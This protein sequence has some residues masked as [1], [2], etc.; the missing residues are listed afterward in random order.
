MRISCREGEGPQ[1]CGRYPW[2]TGAGASFGP[3]LSAWEEADRPTSS[4]GANVFLHAAV[5]FVDPRFDILRRVQ[6]DPGARTK[7]RGR[8]ARLRFVLWLLVHCILE[9]KR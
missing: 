3:G 8:L 7:A 5:V 4:Q 1:R 6:R 9:I 2:P